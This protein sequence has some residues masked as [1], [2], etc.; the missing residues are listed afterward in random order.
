MS[1]KPRVV[2]KATRAPRRSS[3]VFVPTVLP[4]RTLE[5]A[6]FAG[7]ALGHTDPW[8]AEALADRVRL[9]T[10]IPSG[11]PGDDRAHALTA[12]TDPLLA[13]SALRAADRTGAAIPL[14]APP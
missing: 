12:L 1:R 7:R 3:T 14:L 10:A 11:P 8:S 4:W 13:L 2:T 9:T 5:T 6:A